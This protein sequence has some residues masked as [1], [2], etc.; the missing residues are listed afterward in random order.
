MKKKLCILSL[1]VFGILGLVGCG[2]SKENAESDQV[3]METTMVLEENETDGETELDQ[4]EKVTQE[5]TAAGESYSIGEILKKAGL[6]T[7]LGMGTVFA[8]LIFISFLISL[9]KYVPMF[10]ERKEKPRTENISDENERNEIPDEIS[11]KM[12]YEQEVRRTEPVPIKDPQLIAVISA[13]IMAANEPELKETGFVVRSIKRRKSG[14][15][16]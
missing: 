1:L 9:L 14:N 11:E 3:Q 10:F 16:R 8:V 5:S 15:W 6:N 7:V 12:F 4:D 2:S 13:A